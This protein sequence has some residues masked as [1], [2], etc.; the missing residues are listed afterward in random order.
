MGLEEA[1]VEVSYIS[2]SQILGEGGPGVGLT[3]T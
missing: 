1:G 3:G 2:F